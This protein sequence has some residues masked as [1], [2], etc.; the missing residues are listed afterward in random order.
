M[1]NN[2]SNKIKETKI[3]ED[4]KKEER[5][6]E[7]QTQHQFDNK[8]DAISAEQTGGGNDLEPMDEKECSSK[9]CF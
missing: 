5:V 7:K 1:A 2:G 6:I 9:G 3:Q 8:T 4:K